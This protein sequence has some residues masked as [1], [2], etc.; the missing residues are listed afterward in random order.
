MI[1]SILAL[2]LTTSI[3]C[4]GA[5]TPP[6][7]TSVGGCGPSAAT[8][9]HETSGLEALNGMPVECE[10]K[11]CVLRPV[12]QEYVAI[13]HKGIAIGIARP[14]VD[15]SGEMF[16]AYRIFP[17][18]PDT[19]RSATHASQAKGCCGGKDKAAAA[20]SVKEGCCPP[21]RKS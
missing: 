2:A 6:A 5:P 12:N 17:A 11:A 8:S 1:Q 7:A 14:M 16:L 21:A 19:A 15:E 4:G 10:G 3:G 18:E 9:C 13:V 20:A